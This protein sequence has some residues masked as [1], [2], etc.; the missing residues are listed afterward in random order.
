[1]W[2]L[3]ASE[4]KVWLAA[5]ASN[6]LQLWSQLTLAFCCNQTASP[7]PCGYSTTK[8]ATR[9]RLQ[10]CCRRCIVLRTAY[11]RFKA[12]GAVVLP[13]H[14]HS[15]SIC[16]SSSSS[17]SMLPE[18]ANQL[19]WPAHFSHLLQPNNLYKQLLL[20]SFNNICFYNTSTLVGCVLAFPTSW[21]SSTG[22][23]CSLP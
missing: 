18:P 19:R 5:G 6:R 13:L 23:R 17:S 16:N 7:T 14:S 9:E 11:C 20:V 15:S 2:V 1:M 4:H 21:C 3:A 10:G 8:Q 12:P 22:A